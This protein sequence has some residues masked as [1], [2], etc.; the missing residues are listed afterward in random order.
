MVVCGTRLWLSWLPSGAVAVV[1]NSFC[2]GQCHIGQGGVLG[3]DHKLW[4]GF[5][6]VG[7]E[8]ER[9]FEG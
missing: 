5:E 7:L 3:G 8:E 9:F 4:N 6:H 1:N 2:H